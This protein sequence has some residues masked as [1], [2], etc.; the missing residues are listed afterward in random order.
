MWARSCLQNLFCSLEEKQLGVGGCSLW[1]W[2]T[3]RQDYIEPPDH[4]A[5]KWSETLSHVGGQES[6]SSWQ[7]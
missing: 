3:Q 5:L 2:D 1:G 7:L 6:D 4:H